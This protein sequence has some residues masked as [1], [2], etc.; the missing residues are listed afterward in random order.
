[1]S[2]RVKP[3]LKAILNRLKPIGYQA[4]RLYFSLTPRHMPKINSKKWGINFIGYARG[5]LGL[6]QAMRA[7][8]WSTQSASIPFMVRQLEVGLKNK[9]PNRS[10]E[11]YTKNRCQ[12]AVNLICI[13]PDLLYR[14]PIW[15]R[16]SEWAKTYN[17]GYWFWELE[18]FPN[19]WQYARHIVDEIWVATE[20]IANAVQECGKKVVK[21]PFP[22]E[23]DLPPDNL[24]K[25]YFGIDPS[26]FTFLFSF[27]FASTMERKNPQAVIKAFKQ[28]FPIDNQDVLLVIKTSNSNHY[29]ELRKV[30][31]EL[32]NADCRI[33]IRDEYLTEDEMRGLIRSADC[34]ISLHRSEGLGLGLAE[35]MYLGKPTIA[36]GYSGN[37][38]F[39]NASNSI[40]IPFDLV[41]VPAGAYPYGIGQ[42]WADPDIAVA[43]R[44]MQE[45][46]I[47]KD[48]ADQFGRNA[49][50]YM[51]LH[52]SKEKTGLEIKKH[53][54][55]IHKEL[56]W[57]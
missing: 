37:T 40:L 47:D 12:Y 4:A 27:D 8:V 54:E 56:D 34:Y 57:V 43:A 51:K 42:K 9:K 18:K 33:S 38:E 19:A 15:V 50:A 44:I 10:L 2:L 39:M 6:G 20:F 35:A 29:P 14:L 3:I 25:S 46:V 26:A 32:I 16:H 7:M 36:T 21:I 48:L 53:L 11:A 31:D 13:N 49:A 5:E 17:V 22:L 52:H 45:M 1:M 30:L 55:R 24:D 23:F 28:G 41:P